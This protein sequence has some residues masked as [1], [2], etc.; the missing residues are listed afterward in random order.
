MIRIVTSGRL[1]RLH[2]DAEQARTRAREVQ[3]Q[4]DAAWGRHVRETWELTARAETAESDAGILRDHVFELEAALK[5]ARAAFAERREEIRRLR[6]ELEAAR[7]N[8]RWL[9]LLLHYGE[10]HSIHRSQQDA[11]AYAATQG[12]PVHGWV[13]GDERP[14]AEVCWQLIPFTQDEA[15]T[16]FRS[17]TV[18]SQEPMGGAA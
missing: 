6:E 2:E 16:G 1:A 18:P 15:V 3:G 11:Y 10:P 14:A 8:G 9:V 5:D 7:L 12:A 4:A 17:V 13:A